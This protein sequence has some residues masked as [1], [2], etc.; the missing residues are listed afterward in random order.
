[1]RPQKNT[2][3]YDKDFYKWSIQQATLLR[4]GAFTQA[5]MKNIIEEIA[6]LA[7]RDKREAES[8]MV[9]LLMQL[10]IQKYQPEKETN[11]WFRSISNSQTELMLIFKSNS[12][13]NEI[14]KNFLD[15]Y[16]MARR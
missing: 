10:L 13:K 9:N 16:K 15:C 14:N 4:K 5:D 6:D 1:M 2:S 12:L 8:H 11:S 3:L 7:K